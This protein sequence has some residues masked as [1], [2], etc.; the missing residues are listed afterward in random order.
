MRIEEEKVGVVLGSF[1][2]GAWSTLV[3]AVKAFNEAGTRVVSPSDTRLSRIAVNNG[4]F[5]FLQSDIEQA[6]FTEEELAGLSETAIAVKLGF[7]PLQRNVLKNILQMGINGRVYLANNDGILGKSSSYELIVAGLTRKR[8]AV[9]FPVE[10]IS[11]RV[12]PSARDFLQEELLPQVP[13]V[14]LDQL[15]TFEADRLFRAPNLGLTSAEAWHLF[16][17]S[18]NGLLR[19]DQ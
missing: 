13:I 6:G 14:P 10:N 17:T 8:L 4:D 11:P 3:E 16:R 9:N 5:Y 15:S 12:D 1:K 7:L 19:R 18:V 2:N